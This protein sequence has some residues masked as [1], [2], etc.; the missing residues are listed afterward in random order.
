MATLTTGA[1]VTE[2]SGIAAGPTGTGWAAVATLTTGATV[3]EES[4]IA[5]GPTGTG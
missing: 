5:A 1:T 3:T 4:G 2:E